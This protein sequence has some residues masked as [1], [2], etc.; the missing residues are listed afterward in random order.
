MDLIDAYEIDEVDDDT[1]A[2]EGITGY[3]KMCSCYDEDCEDLDHE[4]CFKGDH[5]TGPTD[6]FCPYLI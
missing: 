6:G 1:S 3:T 2:L 5:L 4:A